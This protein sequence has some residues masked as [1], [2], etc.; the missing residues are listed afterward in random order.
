MSGGDDAGNAAPPTGP[1]TDGA[2]DADS[3]ADSHADAAAVA[4][5]S[6]SFGG[7]RA[8]GPLGAAA[9]TARELT[10]WARWSWRQLTSMRV[11]L[12]LLFLLALATVP[13]SL[14][15]QRD[16]NPLLVAEFKD[17]HATLGDLYE[18]FQM[19]EVYSSVW[20]SAVYILLFVSLAGCIVPRTW[21]FAGQLRGRPPRAP[22]RL[23]RMPAYT[24][25]RTARDPD[26]VLRAAHGLL[27][28]GRFR[29]ARAAGSVAA[30]KGYLREA[31]NLLFHGALIVLL[32]AFAAG[33]LY[34][35]E[36]GKLVMAGGGFANTLIQYD[37]F[38]SGALFDA[39]DLEPFH[40]DLDEFHA[41]FHRSGPDLGTP[42]DFRAEVTYW[43]AGDDEDE[44]REATIRVNHPLSVGDAKV[45]LIGHGFAPVVTVTDGQ[46][47]VAFG[48]PV[49][50][51]PQDSALTSSGVIKV[52]DYVNR[53]GEPDQ[54]GFQ[55]FFSPTFRLNAERGPHSSFPD[56]DDPVLTLTGYHGN[57]GLDSGIPQNVYQ[58]N[59]RH[60]EQFT[61][62][63][64]DPLRVNL[65]PGDSWELP[66]GRGTLTFEG[67]ERWASFQ[68]ST[69]A[70]NGWAL[71]GSVGAV[72][73]LTASLLIQ[74]R[75]IWVRAV[76]DRDG[77]PGTTLVE[78]ASLG[79]TESA[80]IPEELG[81]LAAALQAHA[82]PLP[83]PGDTPAEAAAAPG[84]SEKSVASS[85]MPAQPS[86]GH[87]EGAVP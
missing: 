62:G 10:G 29:T 30:E 82:P 59:T 87:R 77:P 26:D 81:D 16:A 36:G 83:G 17:R 70:A 66:D 1:D 35:S 44:G 31:G 41:S 57:L 22:R 50:F 4:P 32:L 74:R 76:P 7:V 43:R 24:S 56:P 72:L 71:A 80:K 18:R 73:G 67:Y 45:Y 21:Q 55:G 37:D 84:T 27:R 85:E 64:G 38:R 63:S 47:E 46:G 52:T 5:G 58:L 48:G 51:L 11:A 42:I 49:P 69:P 34:R 19:F 54:L 39:E 53:D 15:P 33:Q 9:W 23:T 40:F 61:D 2:P 28:R 65:R 6:G 3:N 8:P 14:I 75:R 25:W 86:A 79:R 13:G 12:I 78:M 68:I 60:L 20:F